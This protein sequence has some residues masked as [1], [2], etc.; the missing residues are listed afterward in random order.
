[1]LKNAM[2]GSGDAM[3]AISNNIANAN[4]PGFQRSDVSFKEALAATQGI[5]VDPNALPLALTEA[6][7]HWDA[8]LAAAHRLV[9][10]INHALLVEPDGSPY[11]LDPQLAGANSIAPQPDTTTPRNADEK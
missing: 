4:T 11:A 1:M 8:R 7:S 10:H 3:H 6:I 9:P 5:P 2:T